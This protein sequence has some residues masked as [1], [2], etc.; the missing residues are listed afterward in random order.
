VGADDTDD[1]FDVWAGATHRAVLQ[2]LPG[3]G[4]DRSRFDG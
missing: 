3:A 1:G 2:P 4:A